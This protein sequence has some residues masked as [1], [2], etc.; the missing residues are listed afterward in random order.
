MNI[1][2][3][4]HGTTTDNEQ[5]LATGWNDGVL[6]ERGIEQ[7]KNLGKLLLD[8]KFEVVFCSDLQR[9]IDSANLAFGNRFKVISD[10]R[11]REANYGDY[12]QQSVSIFKNNLVKYIREPFPHGESY[13]EV[14]SRVRSFLQEIIPLYKNKNIATVGH[15]APQLAL[16]V[17]LKNKSW[18]QAISEDW[19][20]T[21]SWQSGWEYIAYTLVEK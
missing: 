21:K 17:I 13:L 15:Q 6:S 7:V 2:Y 18:E 16:D 20:L 11:L 4:V 19:R 5:N 9:A 14:E 1:T 12:T 10:P 8:R 3:F